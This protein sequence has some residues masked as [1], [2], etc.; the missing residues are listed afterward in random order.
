MTFYS[1]TKPR[2]KSS[3]VCQ[4]NH[5][6]QYDITG[7]R[8]RALLRAG[9]KG[10]YGGQGYGTK[11]ATISGQSFPER[12]AGS[13]DQGARILMATGVGPQTSKRV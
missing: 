2:K 4:A 6:G 10:E 7:Y 5:Q 1:S 12:N 11:C 3:H 8:C 13:R 9:V